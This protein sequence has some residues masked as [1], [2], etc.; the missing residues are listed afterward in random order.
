M[1]HNVQ[2]AIGWAYIKGLLS[3]IYIAICPW[4]I[5]SYGPVAFALVTLEILTK[6]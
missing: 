4:P 6:T 2:L 1:Y 3:Y 5:L